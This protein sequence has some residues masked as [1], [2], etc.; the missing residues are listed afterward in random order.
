MYL[1]F[2][3]TISYANNYRHLNGIDIQHSIQSMHN[4]A[5][6]QQMIEYLLVKHYMCSR[7]L[8][9]LSFHTTILTFNGNILNWK[10][11]D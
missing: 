10:T 1:L 4:I 9:M 6:T 8:N 2:F 3:N 11:A 7:L 5:V